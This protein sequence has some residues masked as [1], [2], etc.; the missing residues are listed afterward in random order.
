MYSN[1]WEALERMEAYCFKCKA[2]REMK[3]PTKV[4]MKNGKPRMHGYCVVCNSKM[5]RL[6]KA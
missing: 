5:S 4:W 3:D 1:P 2:T 6:V